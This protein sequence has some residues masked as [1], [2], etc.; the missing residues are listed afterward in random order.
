MAATTPTHPDDPPAVDTELVARLVAG[1]FPEWAD[2]PVR[3]VASAGTDNVMFRLGDDLVVRLPRVPYAARHVEKEQRWL[4]LLAPHLPLDVPV[5][6]GRAGASAEFPWPWSV[7][8]W[9]DGD[10]TY[11]V[12]LTDL[13]HAA[14]ALGRFGAALRAVDASDGPTSFRGGHVTSWEEG[15]LPGVIRDFGAEGLIDAEL[16]TASWEA[17]LRLPQWDGPPVW[18]HGDLLPGNLL[19]R[20]GRLSAVIDFGGVGTGD[21]A[22]DTMPAWTLFTADTRPLFREA[23]RVDDATWARGRGWALAWGLVTEH[24]YRETNPVLAAVAR[25]TRTEALAE[26]AAPVTF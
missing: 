8:R 25:R 4:P 26:Y 20:E 12:P 9:L 6:V 5:P 3:R 2:L 21:P 16:A 22:C 23:A 19:G 14:V 17:V 7:Y 24:Y 18:V 1:R 11:D 10:D 15:H 13:A